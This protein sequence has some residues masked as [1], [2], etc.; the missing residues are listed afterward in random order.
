MRD[1]I[2]AGVAATGSF[3]TGSAFT[4]F[5]GV[6]LS[7]LLMACCGSLIAMSISDPMPTRAKMWGWAAASAFIGTALVSV[8]AHVWGFGWTADVPPQVLG[9][10]GG[11]FCRWLIPGL[12]DLVKEIPAMIR[13]RVN[14][15]D[16]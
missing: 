2:F 9:M 4:P 16:K 5:I 8:Y 14:K 11:F 12:I 13:K 10:L 3:F 7:V 1:L 6:P 15:G